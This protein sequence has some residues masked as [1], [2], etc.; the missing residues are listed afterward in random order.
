MSSSNNNYTTTTP[1]FDNLLLQ[2]LMG[3]L[4]LRQQQPPLPSLQH[5][6]NHLL[7]SQSFED[8]LLNAATNGG[9]LSDF[10]FSDEDGEDF[11]DGGG[12]FKTHLS[13]EESKL[14]K[15]LIKVIL[16]G[17][18]ETLKPN[19]GQAVAI[20]EHHVC[21]GFHEENESDYRVWEWH[22]HIML[23]DEENGY[24][25]EYI[26]GNYFERL[27]GKMKSEK[28]EEE[29]EDI[30]QKVENLG[31]RELIEGGDTTGCRVLHQSRNASSPR[32]LNS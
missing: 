11:S 9:R 30:E 18:T 7:L 17:K 22:G 1:N 6:N 12:D 19:S 10:S 23:F 8:L 5:D 32:S 28:K 3:R 26:Y 25:P 21:V 27:M 4:Q 15:E 16:S 29:V 13:K 20:G 31:L 14:E 24:T 2:S